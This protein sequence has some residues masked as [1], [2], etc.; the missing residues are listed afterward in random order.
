MISLEALDLF[1]GPPSQ[2]DFCCLDTS[3]APTLKLVL[4]SGIDKDKIEK[5]I[6][7]KTISMLV[8]VSQAFH[9]L[10]NENFNYLESLRFGYATK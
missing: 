10:K 9:N 2:S 1:W 3:T 6:I 4:E 5:N 8:I 7:K